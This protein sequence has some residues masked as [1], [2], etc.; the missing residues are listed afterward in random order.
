[1]SYGWGLFYIWRQGNK[2]TDFLK[3]MAS[4]RNNSKKRFSNIVSSPFLS[5]AL[6]PIPLGIPIHFRGKKSPSNFWSHFL[7]GQQDNKTKPISMLCLN[8]LNMEPLITQ[9]TIYL[10]LEHYWTFLHLSQKGYTSTHPHIHRHTFTH[11]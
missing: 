4:G 2:V 9:L 6:L 7:L 1:M 11:T 3:K 8:F 5:K 10:Y